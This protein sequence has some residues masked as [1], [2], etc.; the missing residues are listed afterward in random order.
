[1]FYLWNC[2]LKLNGSLD[3]VNRW[4]FSL[5]TGIWLHSMWHILS[6]NSY[7]RKY[8]FK[9]IWFDIQREI[10]WLFCADHKWDDSLKT[11]GNY[12]WFSKWILWVVVKSYGLPISS[13]SGA[14]VKRAWNTH[15]IYWNECKNLLHNCIEE[16][17][18]H[19]IDFYS[20][21]FIVSD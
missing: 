15:K 6:D 17:Y 9:F 12:D 7:Q 1:M 4:K 3:L 16:Y 13:S 10:R 2:F 14:F 5:G 18:K 8:L 21:L 11:T 19:F 20:N